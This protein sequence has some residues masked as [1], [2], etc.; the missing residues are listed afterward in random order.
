MLKE[1][2]WS[3]IRMSAAE[4]LDI[5]FWAYLGQEGD[6][7]SPS[8]QDGLANQLGFPLQVFAEMLSVGQEIGGIGRVGTHP[9]LRTRSDIVLSS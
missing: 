4:E 3:R 6:L 8:V 2:I 1:R 9:H 7:R 5:L